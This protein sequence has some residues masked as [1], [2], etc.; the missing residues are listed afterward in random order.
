MK[1][2][3]ILLRELAKPGVHS[4]ED[5]GH[6]LGISRAAVSKRMA[7]LRQ[8]G[9][10][11]VAAAG[12]GYCIEAGVRLLDENAIR[13]YL[14]PST[15]DIFT[16]IQIESRLESTNELLQQTTTAPGRARLLLADRKSV[17]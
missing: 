12:Q 2:D 9:L 5:L 8:Q 3:E 10:P 1:S 6:L 16:S 15:R 13:S 4:G 7:Q 11:V 17:V 14:K